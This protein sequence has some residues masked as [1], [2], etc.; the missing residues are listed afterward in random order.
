MDALAA[1]AKSC[2]RAEGF[3]EILIP[4][5][6]EARTAKQ[7][8]RDGIALTP[9]VVQALGKEAELAQVPLPVE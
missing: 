2:P 7:R 8:L 4:G 6:P 3:D 5:E 9:D 1:R